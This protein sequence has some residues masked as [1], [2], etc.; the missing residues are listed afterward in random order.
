MCVCVLVRLLLRSNPSLTCRAA[1][2]RDRLPA[3]L[4]L[5]VPQRQEPAQ[6]E[7]AR[8]LEALGHELSVRPGFSSVQLVHRDETSL[9]GGADPRKGGWPVGVW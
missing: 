3:L 2:R 1:H 4:R 7:Q 5:P 8:K 6:Q 9:V